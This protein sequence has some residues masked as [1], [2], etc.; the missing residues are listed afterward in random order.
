MKKNKTKK[1]KTNIKVCEC[2]GNGGFTTKTVFRCRYCGYIN[3]LE[4][5][6]LITR[7]G[8]DDR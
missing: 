4:H 6:V 5:E 1:K 7:G 2:C 8:I 3:G